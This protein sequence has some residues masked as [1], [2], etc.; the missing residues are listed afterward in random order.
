M[1]F[2]N[3][4]ITIPKAI[5]RRVSRRNFLKSAAL[6]GAVMSMPSVAWAQVSQGSANKQVEP[7]RTLDSVLNHL[8]P[9][10][11]SGPGASEIKALDYLF[12]LIEQQPI[13]DGE[14]AFIKKGVNWLN[15]YTENNLE[16]PFHLLAAQQKESALRAIA[17]S[18]AGENWLSTL[19]TYIFE[20]MLAPS[21]Y[22]GNPNGIGWQ[23]LNHQAGFPMPPIGKR[24][25]ELP[26]YGAIKVTQ[27][28]TI[29]SEQKSQGKA[30]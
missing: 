2:F 30:L 12:N 7:W 9:S 26:A 4:N 14:K 24:Y 16:Q 25:F 22:G 8:L 19:L 11:P 27:I 10:S 20:A 18:E 29:T 3:N 28:E 5:K 15:G 17:N 23:W 13:D 1:S 21:S 6:S